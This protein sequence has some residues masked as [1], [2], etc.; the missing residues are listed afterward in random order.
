MFY[1]INFS[2]YLMLSRSFFTNFGQEPF[3]KIAGKSPGSGSILFAYR[4][5]KSYLADGER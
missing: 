2:Q 3:P 5:P 1:V 4:R